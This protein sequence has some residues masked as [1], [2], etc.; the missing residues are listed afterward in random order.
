MSPR[1]A[2]ALSR[3]QAWQGRAGIAGQGRAGL[4]GQGRPVTQWA[5]QAPGHSPSLSPQGSCI[6]VPDIFVLV[7]KAETGNANLTATELLRLGAGMLLYLTDPTATCAAVRGGQ[8]AAEA[9]AFLT[10]FSSGNPALGWEWELFSSAVSPQPCLDAGHVLQKSTAVSG[11]VAADVAGQVLVTIMYHVLLGDC[12]HALPP[13]H[14]FLG[15]I[16][17]RYGNESQNLTLAGESGQPWQGVTEGSVPPPPAPSSSFQ[18]P[19]NLTNRDV[20]IYSLDPGAGI[21]GSDFTSLSPALIQQQLSRACSGRHLSAP[22]GQLTVAE[23]YIYGSLATLVICLCA[24]LGIVLLLCS[25]CASAYPYIIQGFVSLA[26]GS[27]TGDALLHLIPQVSSWASPGWL[28]VWARGEVPGWLDLGQRVPGW[29]GL[30]GWGPQAA[31]GLSSGRGPALTAPCSAEQRMIPYMITIGDAIH[32]FADGLA[33]GAAFSTSWKTGLA[34]SLAVLCHELPHEL[35]DFAA[36]LH[37]GLSV[38]KALLLNFSSALTAFLGLYIALSV[39]TGE[40]FQAWIFTVAT[41]LFLYVALCD[42]VSDLHAGFPCPRTPALP[43]CPA[44]ERGKVGALIQG[45]C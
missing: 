36:L 23:R 19:G 3:R 2:P 38:K 27:L 41:G 39:T 11:Q 40:E 43:P 8:W 21:S 29:L 28:C 1:G 6:S 22:G 33:V 13:P 17:R 25:A 32:N 20:H 7:G 42:M 44:R 31:G 24:L 45:S 12:F 34:T 14:Y 37:A 26:V 18:R 10:S 30:G 35:G 5:L 16:F 9:G 4:A 15:Y